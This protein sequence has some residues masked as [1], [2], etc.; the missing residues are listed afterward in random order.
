M[1]EEKKIRE[2]LNELA[3]APSRRIARG[4]FKSGRRVELTTRGH[5][6]HYSKYRI[7]EEGDVIDFA[8]GPTIRAAALRQGTSWKKK[9]RIE[10]KT[11]DFRE[12]LRRRKAASLVCL[13]FDTSGSINKDIVRETIKE[14][15]YTLLIDAYQKRDRIALV[16]AQ[17]QIA[18]VIHPFTS[19]LER[20]NKYMREVK[21]EGLS[22]LSS[23][24]Q[25]GIWLLHNKRQGE[26]EARPILVIVTDGS[27][28]QPIVTGG[29]IR[30][31][32]LLASAAIVD[33]GINTLVIDVSEKGS[34][35]ARLIAERSGGIYYHGLKAPR[36]RYFTPI[37]GE[38][39]IKK[40]LVYA[41]I[42]QKIGGIL[43]EGERE[44]LNYDYFE[45][46]R[47]VLPPIKVVAGCKSN[48]DPEHPEDFCSS[49]RTRYNALKKGE[50]L[51]TRT[52]PVPLVEVPIDATMDEIMGAQVKDA[53]PGLLQK[54]NRGILFIENIHLLDPQ[55]RERIL[56]VA[57]RKISTVKERDRTIT[58]P[59]NFIVVATWDPEGWGEIDPEIRKK[60]GLYVSMKE[61]GRSYEDAPME[62]KIE[63]VKQMK[64]YESNPT[65]FREMLEQRRG[66]VFEKMA[67]ARE[68]LPKIQMDYSMRDLAGRV[69]QE[70]DMEGLEAVLM[71]ER[72]MAT[73]A[74][75]E[76]RTEVIMPDFIEAAR[77]AFPARKK[78]PPSL[79]ETPSDLSEQIKLMVRRYAET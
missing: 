19:S 32:L 50:K 70:Y 46:I 31:E 71:L 36:R 77:M 43:V 26:P 37:L 66:E 60:L 27:A 59:T 45:K 25:A 62:E 68:L 54:A 49:C 47:H 39:T 78:T 35:T 6:G 44:L 64:A 33:E 74:A 2:L 55:V 56:E 24:I 8:F 16:S 41:S 72:I 14:I 10:V 21:F 73:I 28:N 48:C 9:G 34:E 12:K 18:E 40:A 5:I 4:R 69:S 58:I 7:P 11:E 53:G 13:V 57:G 52:I 63:I 75:Y 42:N 76:G 15:V 67:H 17:G 65:K 51:M 29:D 3:G 1:I 20:A 38:E 22:P 30:R 61:V 79:E 23:G